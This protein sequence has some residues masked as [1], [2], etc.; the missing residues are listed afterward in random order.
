LSHI[1]LLRPKHWVKNSFL[2]IPAFFSGDLFGQLFNIDLFLGFLAFSFAASCIYVI[3]DYRDIEADRL[4]PKKKK[5]PLASGKVTKNEAIIVMV[6]LVILSVVISYVVGAKFAFVLG[7]YFIMNLGYSFGLKKIAILDI[8]IVA[9][10][11]VLRI[12]A[13]GV[14]SEIAVSQWLMVMIFLL[15]LFIAVAKRRDDV[16]LKEATGADVRL[17]SSK[18]NL[19]FLN[20][21]QSILSAIIVVAYLMYAMSDHVMETFQTYRLYY[22]TIFVIAGVMRYLQISLVENNTGSPTELLYSDRFIQMTLFLWLLSFYL[23]IYSPNLNI[24]Q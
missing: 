7:I 13:G 3:N 2:F 4:H 22:T 18:Y 6:V 21:L 9:I 24:F 11:F 17:A 1:K 14:I 23:I 12:K 20:S 10:G 15:A 5:R 8:M 16:L 19:D